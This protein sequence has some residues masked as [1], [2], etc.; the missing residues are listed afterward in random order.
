MALP[1]FTPEQRTAALNKAR[2]V[3]LARSAVRARLKTGELTFADF[4]DHADAQRIP[5][6]TALKALPG[7]GDVK[8]QKILEAAGITLDRRRVGGLSKA[9]RQR[10]LDELPAPKTDA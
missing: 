3:R 8:A 7:I 2:E 6:L 1:E 5:V 9:A 4:L 10:L